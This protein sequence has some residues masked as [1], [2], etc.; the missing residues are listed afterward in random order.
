MNVVASKIV[1]IFLPITTPNFASG[2]CPCPYL[3]FPINDQRKKIW[4]AGLV[5]GVGG[6][7]YVERQNLDTK[8]FWQAGMRSQN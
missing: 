7:K 2:L 3:N 1:S 5:P 6:S 8:G 4:K